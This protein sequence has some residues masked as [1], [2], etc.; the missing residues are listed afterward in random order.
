[1]GTLGG[2]APISESREKAQASRHPSCVCMCAHALWERMVFSTPAFHPP[3]L[4]DTNEDVLPLLRKQR[5]E[6]RPRAGGQRRDWCGGLRVPGGP[7]QAAF[8]RP[9]FLLWP[10]QGRG[11][12]Q[13]PGARFARVRD[14]LTGRKGFFGIER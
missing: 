8:A 3:S 9:D 13:V 4:T 12:Q 1:M 7:S 11:S 14:N 10:V 2:N 6:G 5:G